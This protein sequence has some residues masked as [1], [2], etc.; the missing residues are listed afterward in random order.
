MQLSDEESNNSLIVELSSI[1]SSAI[2]NDF[3]NNFDLSTTLS[4]SKRQRFRFASDTKN[5]QISNPSQQEQQQIQRSFATTTLFA[6]SSS[7]LMPNNLD[8]EP[9][10]QYPQHNEQSNHPSQCLEC[11]DDDSDTSDSV[12]MSLRVEVKSLVYYLFV[13]HVNIFIMHIVLLYC[14]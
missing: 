8:G 13:Q 14:C 3:N 4:Y 11:C 2:N 6:S 10:N 5:E 7:L 9:Q 1:D 12:A